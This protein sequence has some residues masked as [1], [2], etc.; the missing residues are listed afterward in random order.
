[1]CGHRIDGATLYVDGGGPDE[2]KSTGEWV[3]DRPLS[4]GLTTWPLE[5]PAAGWRVTGT[6]SGLVDGVRYRLYGWTEDSSWS[7][8]GVSFTPAEKERIREGWVRYDGE[9]GGV[10][11][12]LGEFQWAV[13]R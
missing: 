1:M 11:L 7:A 12:P 2:L 9:G 4:E 6:G 13:C 10:T 8:A 3:A 5:V